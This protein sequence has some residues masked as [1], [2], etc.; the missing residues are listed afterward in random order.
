MFA[1][2]NAHRRIDD[3]LAI[4]SPLALADAMDVHISTRSP[5]DV[6][7]LIT[8]SSERMD[9][10]EREQLDLYVK[11]NDAGNTLADR[12]SAFLRENPRA[13][14]ALDRDV[15]DGIL[16]E[17]GDVA[18]EHPR[19][20]LSTRAVALIALVLALAVFPLAAEYSHQ[21]GLLEGLSEPVLLPLPPAPAARFVR[22]VAVA[23]PHRA[24]HAVHRHAVHH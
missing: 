20:R 11:P 10:T 13:I 24:V 19:R 16:A 3:A 12:F 22:R 23:P 9:R 8:R 1:G 6:R 15:I 5:D 4:A 17:L 7:A 18:A 14:A 2:R 21:R